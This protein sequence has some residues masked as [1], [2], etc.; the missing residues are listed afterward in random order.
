MHYLRFCIR[1]GPDVYMLQTE[2]CGELK[3]SRD[4][5]MRGHTL[6]S[7]QSESEYTFVFI[8]F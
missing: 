8:N 3:N 5:S 2:V 6:Y 1:I 7:S 4:I